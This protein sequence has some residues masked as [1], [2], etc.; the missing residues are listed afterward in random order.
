MA[1][2]AED[3]V[4][5]TLADA[6]GLTTLSGTALEIA[7]LCDAMEQAAVLAAASPRRA[8]LADL[9]VGDVIV[10]L[11]IHAGRVGFLVG[12]AG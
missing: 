1:H 10:R 11:G 3:V 9:P 7:A 5:V 4:E 8:W 12:P 6:A 2:I